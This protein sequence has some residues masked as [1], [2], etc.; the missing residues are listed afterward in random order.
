MLRTFGKRAERA[1]ARL[2][3]HASGS[4]QPVCP[5]E[6]RGAA[7]SARAV[8]SLLVVAAEA[9]RPSIAVRSSACGRWHESTRG[10]EAQSP[11]ECHRTCL[12]TLPPSRA[13][14]PP[15]SFS[16][17]AQGS[18]RALSSVASED[19]STPVVSN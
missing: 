8:S 14:D 17:P 2:R 16:P 3:G 7:A 9:S 1:P 13:P 4:M 5:C 10:D 6:A 12:R 18:A 15:C 11:R 19:F